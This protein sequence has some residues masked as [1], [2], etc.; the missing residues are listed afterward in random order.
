MGVGRFRGF[1]A[2]LG[3]SGPPEASGSLRK[4]PR[5]RGRGPRSRRAAVGSGWGGNLT[6]GESL[7]RG[8][9]CVFAASKVGGGGGPDFRTQAYVA[10]GA[11]R[12]HLNMVVSIGAPQ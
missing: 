10:G 1:S 5:A 4:R 8:L 11:V 2:F 7:Q 12:S 9:H 6:E 3:A